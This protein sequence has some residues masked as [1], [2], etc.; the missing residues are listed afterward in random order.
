MLILSYHHTCLHIIASIFSFLRTT[1]GPRKV[2]LIK[3][4][5]VNGQVIP[6][7]DRRFCS[8]IYY[9]VVKFYYRAVARILEPPT[10]NP[11]LPSLRHSFRVSLALIFDPQES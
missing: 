8:K 7:S 10:W 2:T 1:H 11:D 6:L 4:V 3:T 9:R 5:N